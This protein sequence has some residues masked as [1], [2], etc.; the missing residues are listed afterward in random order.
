MPVSQ[1]EVL[2]GVLGCGI[3]TP[4]M[5][6]WDSSSWKLPCLKLDFQKCEFEA[7]SC[8]CYLFGPVVSSCSLLKVRHLSG[9]RVED[10]ASKA[11]RRN[12]S[13]FVQYSS[14]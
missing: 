13:D 12:L 9:R 4:A 2:S 5:Y 3:Q 7:M 10:C 14:L 11:G 6:L 1:P 8:C